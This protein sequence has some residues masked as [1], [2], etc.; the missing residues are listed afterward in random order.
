MRNLVGSIIAS[1]VSILCIP[2]S[3]LVWGKI[4][5]LSKNAVM[6]IAMVPGEYDETF[7]DDE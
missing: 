1:V 6:I 2:I 4:S 5:Q 3:I 7:E